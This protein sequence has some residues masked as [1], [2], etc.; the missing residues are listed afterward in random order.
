MLFRKKKV[1]ETAKGSPSGTLIVKEL[2]GEKSG[3]EK[4]LL[5]MF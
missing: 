4:G 3:L 1:E 2:R 5:M